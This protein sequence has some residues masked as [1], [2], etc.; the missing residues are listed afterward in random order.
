MQKSGPR[1]D[2]FAAMNAKTRRS[3]NLLLLS[4]WALVAVVIFKDG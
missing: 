3:Q 4:I 2:D 1:D